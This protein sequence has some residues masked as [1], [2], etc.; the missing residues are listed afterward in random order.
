MDILKCLRYISVVTDLFLITILLCIINCNFKQTT[1]TTWCDKNQY[2]C[3]LFLGNIGSMISNMNLARVDFQNRMDGV[4]QYMAFRY[5]L[6]PNAKKNYLRHE[7]ALI[8]WKLI[9]CQN[10]SMFMSSMNSKILSRFHNVLSQGYCGT[11]ILNTFVTT[12][13]GGRNKGLYFITMFC[14][15]Y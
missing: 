5:D 2:N 11:N 13:K 12:R 14:A 6:L 10:F 15:Y 9:R 4:K 3:Y 8:S 1:E 7:I